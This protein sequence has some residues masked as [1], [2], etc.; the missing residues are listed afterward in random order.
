MLVRVYVNVQR[1]LASF[2][3]DEHDPFDCRNRVYYYD[4]T[5]T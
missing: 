2:V 1:E 3:I 5:E 4:Y